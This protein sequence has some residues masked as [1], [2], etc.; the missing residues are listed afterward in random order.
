MKFANTWH[1][2]SPLLMIAG[3]I[4]IAWASLRSDRRRE[5]RVWKEHRLATD[6]RDWHGA[7]MR[8][9]KRGRRL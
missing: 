7:F 4:I 6:D 1:I 8:D 3:S 9:Q 5:E 2:L